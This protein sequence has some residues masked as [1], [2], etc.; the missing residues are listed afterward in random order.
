MLTSVN[1]RFWLSY[2]ICTAVEI[3]EIVSF[4]SSVDR[5]PLSRFGSQKK[6]LLGLPIK[7]KSKFVSQL[8]TNYHS[9]VI[10]ETNVYRGGSMIF[11]EKLGGGA[12]KIIVYVR[13]CISRARSPKSLSAGVQRALLMSVE[14]FRDL[15]ALS[16]LSD[17][18]EI[19][20]VYQAF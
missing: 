2:F 18:V 1:S 12:Q 11:I 14:V 10:V 4:T 15:D 20:D 7:I 13:A 8:V 9:Q 3:E 17:S 6:S 16:V 5:R 19:A